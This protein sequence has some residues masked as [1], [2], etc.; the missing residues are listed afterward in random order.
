MNIT[1]ECLP[2]IKESSSGYSEETIT[3]A[4]KH[5]EWACKQFSVEQRNFLKSQL[6]P[7][8]EAIVG[9]TCRDIEEFSD[10]LFSEFLRKWPIPGL[11]EMN[12]VDRCLLLK[13]LEKSK[14][15]YAK[16]REV[17]LAQRR[18]AYRANHLTRRKLTKEEQKAWHAE[19]SRR[20]YHKRKALQWAAEETVRTKRLSSS[21]SSN[22][23][24]E[25][26]SCSMST[27]TDISLHDTDNCERPN[28]PAPS[29]PESISSIRSSPPSNGIQHSPSPTPSPV[30]ASVGHSDPSRMT[31]AK[32]R[33]TTRNGRE[34]RAPVKLW[35]WRAE[36]TLRKFKLEL[37]G[38]SD[39][40]YL[41]DMYH[42]FF[43]TYKRGGVGSHFLLEDADVLMERFLDEV[44][45]CLDAILDIR[46]IGRMFTEVQAIYQR[47]SQVHSGI[48]ELLSKILSGDGQSL[49]DLYQRKRLIFQSW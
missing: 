17:I 13:E 30:P 8:L 37:D 32:Y 26:G 35:R 7:M 21:P 27:S 31:V 46:G 38:R 15:S 34:V 43:C 2:E 11:W 4:K 42:G 39:V 48:Q 47:I 14:Q 1:Q 9:E 49:V 44:K 22:F 45:P 10:R 16:N 23:E 18:E 40:D 19:S 28:S 25:N 33:C 41:E 3:T 36:Q 20:S 6:D 29:S 5:A 12:A 24:V